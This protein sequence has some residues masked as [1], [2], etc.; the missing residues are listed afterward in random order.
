MKVYDFSVI[1]RHTFTVACSDIWSG[2][3]RELE[4]KSPIFI[5]RMYFVAFCSCIFGFA[6]VFRQDWVEDLSI[7]DAKKLVAKV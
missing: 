2:N 6:E 1:D 4:C 7:E 5:Q 3:L